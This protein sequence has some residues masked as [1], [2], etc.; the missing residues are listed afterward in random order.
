[1]SYIISKQIRLSIAIL[2]CFTCFHSISAQTYK[3]SADST[4]TISNIS[5]NRTSK[6]IDPAFKIQAIPNTH[7]LIIASFKKEKAAIRKLKE[8]G[9]KYPPLKHQIGIIYTDNNYRIGVLNLKTKRDTK[10]YKRN[11]EKDY[12]SFHD[13]W[14][15]YYKGEE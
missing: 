5:T 9:T 13:A 15:Y 11:L 14:S 12:H 8:F 1:M 6:E 2:C 7:V 4:T 3:A 10:S